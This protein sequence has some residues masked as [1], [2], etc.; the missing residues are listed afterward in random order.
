[1]WRSCH[2]PLS[3]AAALPPT[4][5]CCSPVGRGATSLAL[6]EEL[7]LQRQTLVSAAAAKNRYLWHAGGLVALPSSPAAA[8]ASPLIRTVA[9]QAV[10]RDLLGRHQQ[11][12]QHQQ[13]RTPQPHATAAAATGGTDDDE[14]V[15]SW[16]TRHLGPVAADVLLDAAL[17]GIYAGDPSAMS[18]RSV[19]PSLWAMERSP[20]AGPR[21]SVIRAAVA[22]ALREAAAAAA[23]APPRLLARLRRARGGAG[24]MHSR[25]QARGP[26]QPSAFVRACSSASSVSFL[27]GLGT[28]PRAL[29]DALTT[30]SSSAGG[31]GGGADPAD[32]VHA[33]IVT[34]AAVTALRPVVAATAFSGGAQT[35]AAAFGAG[36]GVACATTGVEVAYTTSA[37]PGGTATVTTLIAD[38]VIC[39]LPAHALARVLPA[40]AAAQAAAAAPTAT[41]DGSS[42]GSPPPPPSLAS[43]VASLRAIPFASVAAVNLGWAGR[44]VLPPTLAGFGHL[45]PRRD[46]HWK[47]GARAE[48]TAAAFESASATNAAG[49]A[50]SS[51]GPTANNG[52]LGCTWD[53][54]VFPGQAPSFAG[55]VEAGAVQPRRDAAT[56][57]LLPWAADDVPPRV[58]ASAGTRLTVMIGGA[59]F[60]RDALAAMPPGELVAI[61]RRAAREHLG[62]TAPPD[63]TSVHVALDAIPQYALGHA[64]RV[65]SVTAGLAAAFGGRVTPIGYSYTGIGLSD[66]IA[67]GLA[68]GRAVAERVTGGDALADSAALDPVNAD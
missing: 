14:T 6:V 43:V 35:A 49:D 32:G 26:Q 27:H 42:D 45:V 16:A 28:L 56:G 40:A 46:R 12:Q 65:A 51:P 47:T 64:G 48:E 5:F 7:G 1:V 13:Q 21:G 22:G 67:N 60:P 54:D 10:E 59:T 15:R 24:D 44:R 20:A 53:S 58:A 34:G 18:A 3:C 37:T 11:Q 62:I 66:V 4:T 36:G 39:A 9:V 68:T 29:A 23:A 33:T 61:A 57:T 55:A 2:L 38:E 8:L 41:V 19:L 30:P 31:G 63:T 25:Q 52:V 17:S 50:S